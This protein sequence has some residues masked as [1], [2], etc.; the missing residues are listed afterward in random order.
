MKF[1]NAEDC[2]RKSDQESEMACLAAIDGD[3]EDAAKRFEIARLWRS[4]AADGGYLD[5]LS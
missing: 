3:S 5:D 4:R 1:Y 2:Q